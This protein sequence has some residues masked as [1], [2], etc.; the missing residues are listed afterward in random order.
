MFMNQRL[1][2]CITNELP[3][4]QERLNTFLSKQVKE[5]LNQLLTLI[6]I[7]VSAFRQH[8]PQNWNSH[9][10]IGNTDHQ[11]IDIGHSVLPVGAVQT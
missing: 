4:C 10:L 3:V 5:A 11:N 2:P 6:G 1:E 7:G 8:G 9:T